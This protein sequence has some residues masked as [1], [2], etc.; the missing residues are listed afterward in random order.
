VDDAGLVRV[1]ERGKQ[2][3]H[4]AHELPRLEAN[5]V[6]EAVLEVLAADELHH[7]ERDVGLLAEVVHLDDVR[8]VQPRHRLRLFAEAHRVLAG[9]LLVEVALEDGLD[10]D[11]AVQLRVE[12]LVHDAHGA[13]A[14]LAAELVAA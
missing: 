13:A 1:V 2:F 9:D 7:D 8:V 6:V 3:A 4:Q 12:R 5:V 11:R 14:D 10:G